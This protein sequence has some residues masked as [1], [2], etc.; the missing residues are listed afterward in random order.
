MTTIS[1][2]VKWSPIGAIELKRSYQRNFRNATI[3]VAAAWAFVFLVIVVI[4]MLSGQEAA[5]VGTIVIRDISQL[6]PPPSVATKPQQ[7]KVTQEIAAPK[8]SLPE[9]VPDEEV[10]EDYVVVSQEQLAEMTAP[11]ITEGEGSGGNIRVDIPLEEYLPQADEF[12]AYEELPVA[13]SLATPIYPPMAQKAQIEGTVQVKVL[14]DKNGNVRDAIV[15]KSS[16]ANA[17]FEEAALEAAKKGKWK[18]AIQNKQPVAVW[19]SYPIHFQMTT[20]R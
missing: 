16:G 1:H 5:G 15:V 17:G 10:T 20:R 2:S 3:L 4:R 8:F 7:V 9:A 18:P 12:V 14:V 13:I 11:S 19:V 6:G